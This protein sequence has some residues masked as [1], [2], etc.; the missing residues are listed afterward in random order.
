MSDFGSNL[1]QLRMAQNM[2]QD[3]LAELLGTSKQVISRYENGQRSP[4]VSV[5]GEFARVLGVSIS[6][7][8][9]ETGA[10]THASEA[11]GMPW[12]LCESESELLTIYRDLN[13]LGQTTLIGTARGLAANPDMRKDGTS[14]NE[15][16]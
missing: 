3:D 1:K 15:T 12:Q 7:L 5:V 10:P 6:E 2:T 11:N 9:G 8:T 4:K 14:K 13:T 16:A